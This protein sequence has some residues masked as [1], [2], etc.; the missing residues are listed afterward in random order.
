MLLEVQSNILK[1]NKLSNNKGENRII[2]NYDIIISGG[3][4]MG[5]ITGSLLA[6]KG[7]NVLILE[8]QKHPRWK[9][10]GE[11]ISIRG[12]DLLKKCDLYK[13][14]KNLLWGIKGVSVNILNENIDSKRF[15][16]NVA[17]TLNRTIFD[18]ELF[19]HAQKLG[20]IA[21]ENEKVIKI[22]NNENMVTVKT[23]KNEY[24]SKIIIGADG[25]FSIVGKQLFRPWTRDE[26]V[27]GQVAKYKINTDEKHGFE[28]S[29]MEYYFIKD[30]YGWVFPRVEEKNLI[31]NI[32]I[33]KIKN[34]NQN[35]N[36]LF[37]NFITSL[38][39]E[40]QIKLKGKETKDKT[41]IH[42]IPI[43]GTNR[44]TFTKRCLLVGDAG[45][46]VNPL[47]GA[48]LRY[49]I[50]STIH[51]ADTSIQFLNNKIETLE[52]YEKNWSKDLKNIFDESLKKSKY[53]YT[54]EPAQ[55]I[56]Y[57][58]DNLDIK[59]DLFKAFLVGTPS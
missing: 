11:G 41:C 25:V 52:N 2:K 32:G 46:F 1:K 53:L 24:K 54:L 34:T 22:K 57:L 28:Q 17:Y 42:P 4:P 29:T 26:I 7:F 48:G 40:N 49:G 58:K 20:I 8:K 27:P 21:H 14:L 30:G 47:T 5:S 37:K 55:L 31:L 23:D 16:K 39:K 36:V 44:G 51:A 9:P 38:E 18:H 56:K 35:L 19:K 33:G 50:I 43:K 45:G 13:P 10:C 3:G 15:Q 12:I 59:T 6:K